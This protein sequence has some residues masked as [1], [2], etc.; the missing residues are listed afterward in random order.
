MSRSDMSRPDPNSVGGRG[1]A[2]PTAGLCLEVVLKADA[3]GSVEAVAQ[4]VAGLHVPG[5]E[6]RLIASGVGDITKSDVLMATT[7]S[8]MVI[9]FEVRTGPRVEEQAREQGVEIRLYQVIYDLARELE[10]IAR[11]LTPRAVQERITGQADVIALFKSTRKGIILG[12]AV[13]KGSLA[14]GKNFRVI[15]A[16][17]PVYEGVVSSLHVEQETVREARVGQQVGLKIPDFQKARVGDQVECFETLP[18][19]GPPPWSPQGGV[20]RRKT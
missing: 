7:G 13:R 19:S 12:C 10:E 3:M 17:G 6:I 8:H 18:P 14:V 5:V 11:S 9:G 15:D 4:L 16:A 2:S 1:Q 20:A